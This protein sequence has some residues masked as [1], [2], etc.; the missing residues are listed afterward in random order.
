MTKRG[1]GSKN[2]VGIDPDERA[3]LRAG[4]SARAAEKRWFAL[5]TWS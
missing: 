4:W 3:S 1:N 5:S 2:G